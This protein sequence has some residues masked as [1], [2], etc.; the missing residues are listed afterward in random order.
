MQG[1]GAL[2]GVHG[3]GGEGGRTGVVQKGEAVNGEWRNKR[4]SKRI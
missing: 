3:H 2:V 4:N 1:W